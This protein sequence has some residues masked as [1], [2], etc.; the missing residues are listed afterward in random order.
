MNPLGA[1]IS[2]ALNHYEFLGVD[3]TASSF[4]LRA[5]VSRRRTELER[6]RD[7]AG[8]QR[9]RAAERT[10]L[11]TPRRGTYDAT[12]VAEP[13]AVGGDGRDVRRCARRLLCPQTQ[14]KVRVA[15]QD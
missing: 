10:P 12:L 5:A 4:E 1:P 2:D 15:S 7:N 3:R 11:W 13:D 8:I 9:L 6:A 14:E